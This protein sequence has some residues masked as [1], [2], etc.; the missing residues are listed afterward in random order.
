MTAPGER[1]AAEAEPAAARAWPRSTA[2]YV[3]LALA[4]YGPVLRSDPGKV[5]ADTK[6]YLYLDPGRLL[7]RAASMWDPHIGMGTVTHQNIGYLFP[8]GPYYWILD[9]IGVPDWVAQRLWLGSILFFAG[10]GVLY[11]LRTFGIRGPGVVVAAVAYMFTPYTLDYSARISVLLLPFAAL[12]WMIGLTR[13]ALRDGGWRYPATFALVVQVI[14]GVNATALIFAGLG[15]V[16]WIAYAWLVDR[17][18]DWRRALGVTARIG[19]LTLVTSLWWI[20][21]LE[22]QGTYG[23]D[24]LKY[25]ET[26]RAVATASSPNEILRGLGYW[27]FYGGD[28][29]GPWIES[30][31]QYTQRPVVLL[32]GYGLV[33]ASLLVAGILRWRHRLFFVVLLIA[34]MIIAVGPS[35]YAHPTPLGAI[36]KAF[37]NSSSAGLAL[38]STARAVPLVVLAL[39]VLL[40]VGLNAIFAALR[41]RGQSVL[42][43]AGVGIVM[44]LVV[45]NLPALFDGSY[46]GKNLERSEQVPAYWKTAIK[47]LDSQVHSTRVLEA[48]GADF[49]AYAWGNTVDPITP[50]LMDRPYVARE[51]IPYGTAGT[52]DLLN[53]LDR[54]FQERLADPAGIAAVLRRMGIGA[55][56]LRNDIQ[57]QRYNLVAP[58]EINRLFAQTPGLGRPIGFGSPAPPALAN[59][60]PGSR[61]EDEVDLA[62]PANEPLLNPVVVYPVDDP[63]A[64]VR[65]EPATSSLMIAGDGEGLVD[66]A[67][68]GLLASVGV[69]QYSASYPTRAKLRAAVAPD[70][71]LVVTDENRSRARIW[72]TVLDNVGYTEQAGEKPLVNDP[73]DARLPLFPGQAA[74]ALTTTQQRGIKSIQASAYG[75]TISYT[76]EDRAARALDGDVTTAWRAAALGN[77]VGQR[78]R[79]QLAAPITADHVNLVQPLTSS[80][81]RWLT[82]VALRFDGGSPQ[83][84]TL[85]ASSRAAKGQTIS[86]TR[87]RFSTLEIRITAVNDPRR[88]LFAGADGVGLAEIRVR[89]VHARHDVRVEEVEQMPQDLLGALGPDVAKHPL[90]ILMSRDAVRGIP[91]RTDPE[92]ALAR[93][94]TLPGSRSFALTG[95][96]G[97]NPAAP[98][99]VIDAAL[100]MGSTVTATASASLAACLECHGASAADGNPATVWNTPFVNVSGQWVQFTSRRPITFS[101]MNLQVVADGRH[102]VPT[103]I[104]ID[105]D[106][107]VRALSLPPIADAT[108]ENATTT[109]ALRFPAM[110]GRRVR[111]KI[112][113]TRVQMATRE[114]TG[115]KVTAPVAIAE[116]GI[117]GLGVAPA[118]AAMPAPCRSDLLSIDG[119]A[120][121]VRVSGDTKAAGNLSGLAVTPCD[122]RDPS[123][124]PTITLG[125]G[126][127]VVRTSEGLRT[128]VQLDRVVLAS[129]AGDGHFAVAGGQVTLLGAQSATA[130]KVTVVHNGATRMRVHVSGARDPFWLVLGESQSDGWK[131]TVA[132]G[133][134]LG[135]SRLVDGYANGWLLRPEH[136]SF[137]VVIE[138]TPQRRVW[139]AIWIS[140]LAALLCFALIAWSMRRG[141]AAVDVLGGAP[142]DA[143]ARV[144]W[145]ARPR[146]TL[147]PTRRSRVVV[148]ILAGLVATL[149]VAPWAGALAAAAVVLVQWRPSLRLLVAVTPAALIAVVAV[150]M[151]YLQHHFRFPPVFEWP[152]LF[153]LGRPLG[154]LAV[155]F[156]GVD[157]L[158]ERVRTPPAGA[159][160]GDSDPEVPGQ[161]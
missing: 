141:R 103:A 146:G 154:W 27:F 23:L 151:V 144:E 57:S 123:R 128:G 32:A 58:R 21:G 5:A 118:P 158:V 89:D 122:P 11:L 92:P 136:A 101:H 87:R 6:Q 77:A 3:L 88:K 78:I 12:P 134:S 59:P 147:A 119:H 161:M 127:H 152:T 113:G 72:S 62:A 7:A 91:P 120:V 96:A 31:N 95:R 148:P 138:W 1:S 33:V 41:R 73:N 40:G 137:D 90:I 18:V 159:A 65:A 126:T 70:A 139:A 85:D 29:V 61:E 51:L 74:S 149:V 42:G 76:P 86:F 56:V 108:P 46:Y 133:G 135:S 13:K 81:N 100:G 35:P 36:F 34:G 142:S 37:A 48:P 43:A 64:I 82:K 99:R 19:V 93:T 44:L 117:P 84:A 45:V 143:D 131:A 129:A 71:T 79:L 54:R 50:G 157:V 22:M 47:H 105:V 114:S 153:P 80:R 130:P 49:A 109:V 150:Y 140:V 67:D 39:A 4:A 160:A 60:L 125:R 68:M 30:A 94:F 104:E 14:G 116:L 15:A 63:S 97:V 24:I 112:I 83:A 20:A 26:V 55:V 145:P 17:E 25:T 16:L 156:L 69:T 9:R 124:V 38:R 102:S 121:P 28:R 75:N 52:A 115:D 53:A 107:A 111:V 8:M 66:V 110:T 2:G 98:D 10:A 132:G 106:G 155:V